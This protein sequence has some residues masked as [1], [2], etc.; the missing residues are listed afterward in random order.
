MKLPPILINSFPKS[1]THLLAQM[2][3]PMAEAN[4][5]L[6]GERK[7]VRY[8]STHDN[9]GWG[10]GYRREEAVLADLQLLEP[11]QYAGSHIAAYINVM[12]FL[13]SSGWPIIFLYRD[14]RDIA[15]SEVYHIEKES[16]FARHPFKK[17]I[18]ELPTH[19]DRLRAVIEGY[20]GH[21]PLR[22]RWEEYAPWLASKLVLPIRFRDARLQPKLTAKAILGFISWRTN[23]DFDKEAGA[24]YMVGSIREQSSPTF[25][26]GR[27]G[28]HI[29]EFGCDLK[30][31]AERELGAWCEALGF[32]EE[33]EREEA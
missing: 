18:N 3:S 22:E 1:G 27:I 33:P 5:V 16:E 15:V 9:G 28:D 32:N 13:E 12:E 30:E 29:V 21:K 10:P 17:A 8:L 31:I 7:N 2:I 6:T 4:P 19:E 20:K 26:A 25:R 11:G 14:L 24:G 23:I